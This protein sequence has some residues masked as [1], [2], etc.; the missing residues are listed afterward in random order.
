MERALVTGAAG[1]LGS[2][3]CERLLDRGQP[4]VGLDALTDYYDPVLKR[5]NLERSLGND[6][7]TFVEEDL[8]RVDLVPLLDGTGV[9]YHL[10]AQAGVR[11]S[12]GWAFTPY[13]ERNVAATQRLLEAVRSL[14]R[15]PRV[16]NASSSSV[17]GETDALPM[18]EGDLPRPHSPYGVTKLA[19]EH[20]CVL[21][22]RNYGVPCV[23][24][25][26]FTVFGPRQRPDMAFHRFT[27]ALLAGEELRVFGDGK[28]TRDFTYVDDAVEANLL[29]AG[30]EGREEVFNI[31]GGTRAT[32]LE[33]IAAL[34]AIIGREPPVRHEGRVH[35]DVVHTWADTSLARAELGFEPR[36]S[37]REGL[38]AQVAWHR[39]LRDFETKGKA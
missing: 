28:Q 37:L 30:Y 15:R 13:L 1:F 6:A 18:R 23:S 33:A 12:W 27:A 25:R 8:N 7:F 16:V 24:L 35:G 3:L 20:L 14:G 36:V 4:V 22:R 26:Y 39:E 11:S 29:A 34:G 19:A 21:Y 17:Y 10:A 5:R 31:G 32:L 2:R 38:E 9:V